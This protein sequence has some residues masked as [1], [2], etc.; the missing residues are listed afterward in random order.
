MPAAPG[1]PWSAVEYAPL[2]LV[3]WGYGALLSEAIW[4]SRNPKCANAP[5]SVLTVACRNSIY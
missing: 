1:P 4:S 2:I 3:V 5:R